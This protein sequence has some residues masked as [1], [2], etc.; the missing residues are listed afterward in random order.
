[1]MGV[2][3]PRHSAAL[4]Q[5]GGDR[6]EM[7]RWTFT[8]RGSFLPLRNLEAE[9]KTRRTTSSQL[10][11]LLSSFSHHSYPYGKAAFLMSSSP[12]LF[13]AYIIVSP[14]LAIINASSFASF[15]KI[16]FSVTSINPSSLSSHYDTIRSGIVHSYLPLLHRD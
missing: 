2:M 4:C 3:L 5:L 15:S 11:S 10:L 9:T 14:T 13:V 8:G 7:L 1:M 16:S 6:M 12:F